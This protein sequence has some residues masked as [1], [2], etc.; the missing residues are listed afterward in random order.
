M[1]LFTVVV[2]RASRSGDPLLQNPPEYLMRRQRQLRR[3]YARQAYQTK[4]DSIS[5][6]TTAARN[7]C[8]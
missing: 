2:A 7:L 4:K 1:Q 3:L 6:P 5:R 8:A